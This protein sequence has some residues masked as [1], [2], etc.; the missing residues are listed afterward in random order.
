MLRAYAYLLLWSCQSPWP[1]F[2]SSPP[3]SVLLSLPLAPCQTQRRHFLGLFPFPRSLHLRYH[4]HPH[5]QKQHR[6]QALLHTM[7]RQA[8][9]LSIAALLPANCNAPLVRPSSGT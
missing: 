5:Q 9:S 6:Q 3:S 2:S 4:S 1:V 7:L 8:P